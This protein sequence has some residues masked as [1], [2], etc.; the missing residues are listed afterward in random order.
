[1]ESEPSLSSSSSEMW[2]P[3]AGPVAI[4]RQAFMHIVCTWGAVSARWPA[5]VAG[6]ARLTKVRIALYISYGVCSRWTLVWLSAAKKT[7]KGSCTFV[8][9][10]F[11]PC[12]I[13]NVIRS[14]ARGTL[15]DVQKGAAEEP[16]RGC[17]NSK[18]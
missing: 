2:P 10:V 18:P 13:A 5:V 15:Q 9:S 4:A 3:A 14:L 16:L 12:L 6:N 8:L 7:L 17:L 11:Y 1:M